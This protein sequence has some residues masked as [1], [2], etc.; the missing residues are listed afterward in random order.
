M[1]FMKIE[2]CDEGSD[3]VGLHVLEAARKEAAAL[4]QR[5]PFLAQSG[6]R[7]I[8]ETIQKRYP[9]YLERVLAG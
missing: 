4:V 7:L 5:D 8:K 6:H 3:E 2:I 1:Y 9:E